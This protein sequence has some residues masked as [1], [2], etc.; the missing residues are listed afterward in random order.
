MKRKVSVCAGVMA[1][2]VAMSAGAEESK[3]AEQAPVP[4]ADATGSAAPAVEGPGVERAM[5][6][7]PLVEA[8][9]VGTTGA[10]AAPDAP[11]A[12]QAQAK[13]GADEVHVPFSFAVVPGLSTSG[14]SQRN[15]VHDVSIGLIATQAKR[16]RALGLSL[17]GNFVGEGGSS[18]VLATTGVNIVQGPVNGSL[19]AVGGNILTKDSEGLLASVGTN[20]VRGGATGVLASVGANVVTGSLDGSQMTVGAN[21]VTGKVLGAQLGV[22]GN[23]AGESL[24]GLQMAVGGNV[25]SGVSRGVQMAAGVNVASDL[26]GLQMSSGVS[27]AGKLSGAQVS[28]I[29]VGGSVDGAQ[30]GLVNV[31]SRIDG[32]QV[33]LVNVAGE[34]Q[35]ESVGLLSFVG[36]GQA[37]VQVWASDVALTNLS[38]KLGGQHIYTLLNVGLT[39]PMGGDRRRYTMGLG[40]GGHIP[41][42]R[43]F[44]DM[45]L[46]G[47]SVHANRLFDFEDDTNHVLGQLRLIAGWQVARRFAVFGGVSANTLVTWNG[48]DPWKELGIGPEWKETSESGRTTV[49][50]WPGILAG[51]QI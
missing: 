21:V 16:I 11:T 35:G 9:A 10:A 48:S 18:G 13:A 26:S 24:N 40:I 22:G 27:Y 17:G 4:A 34:T 14:F 3:G 46:M 6:A 23:L 25:A 15:Q 1:A 32:A 36:N 44:V 29:N 51:I 37:N 49:R 50:T 5:A 45:D 8:A 7:P 42:G 39:P 31:A 2:M 20:I 33:G 43:F 28:I 47:S 41:L 38:L 19:F 12:V 30:V